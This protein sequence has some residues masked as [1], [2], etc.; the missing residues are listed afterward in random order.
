MTQRVLRSPHEDLADAIEHVEDSEPGVSVVERGG[1]RGSREHVWVARPGSVAGTCRRGELE[2]MVDGARGRRGGI[3]DA[4]KH[5]RGTVFGL[6]QV[7][8]YTGDLRRAATPSITHGKA[9]ESATG[10]K[11]IVGFQ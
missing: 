7:P 2:G 9:K 1:A 5:A 11:E 4:V 3:E 8:E 10:I 6:R